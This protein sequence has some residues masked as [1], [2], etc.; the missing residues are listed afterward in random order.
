MRQREETEQRSEAEILRARLDAAAA[1]E[2][3]LRRLLLE[4]YGELEQKRALVRMKRAAERVRHRLGRRLRFLGV[5][6]RH[7]RSLLR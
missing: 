2:A 4:A 6:R 5:L 1:R 7:A 3:E